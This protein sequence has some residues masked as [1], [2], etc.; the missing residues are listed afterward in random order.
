MGSGGT[1]RLNE[2]GQEADGLEP[3]LYLQNLVA[4]AGGAVRGRSCLLLY[5]YMIMIM[6]LIKEEMG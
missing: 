1:L 5:G 3:P 4:V 2:G 6:I